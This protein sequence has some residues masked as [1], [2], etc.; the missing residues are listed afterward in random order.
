[1][2]C[3]TLSVKWKIQCQSGGDININS[4]LCMRK[5]LPGLLAVLASV[6]RFD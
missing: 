4:V 3:A 6:W 5:E 1:M 2:R